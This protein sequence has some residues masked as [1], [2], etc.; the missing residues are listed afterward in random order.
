MTP[1]LTAKDAIAR[2]M[3]WRMTL[4]F[5]IA[6][7]E[8]VP[9]DQYAQICHDGQC[10]IGVWLVSP[11]TRGIR[12]EAPYAELVLRHYEFHR[13]MERVAD[14]IGLGEF[15]AAAHAME[16]DSSF[17]RAS[18]AIAMAIMAVNRLLVLAVPG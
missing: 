10:A 14:L 5:A 18:Q 16:P 13:E 12:G 4:Q 17:R 8:P 9:P 6:V 1:I 11:A 7:R 15:D 2:H 3:Q